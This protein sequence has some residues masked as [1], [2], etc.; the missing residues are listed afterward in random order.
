MTRERAFSFS[1]DTSATMRAGAGTGTGA[2]VGIGAPAFRTAL[3]ILCKSSSEYLRTLV[4][5]RAL[6]TRGFGP[7][8]LAGWS[9]N[10]SPNSGGG[11]ESEGA[12]KGATKGAT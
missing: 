8:G 4:A 6:V 12:T 10:S 11:E 3:R 9:D 7:E 1:Q 2:G 5:I